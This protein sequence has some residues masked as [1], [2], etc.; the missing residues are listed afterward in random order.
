MMARRITA[1]ALACAALAGCS[2]FSRPKN[3]FYTLETL[4]PATAPA[5]DLVR[6]LPIGIDALE[7]PPG[8]D[9]RGIV[10]LGPDHKVEVRGTNQWTSDLQ[11]MVL[12]TLAFDLADRLPEGMVVLP[13]Q[14]KPDAMRSISI[15]FD[16]LAAGPA[17]AFVLDARWTL[18]T[19]THREQISLPLA[20]MESP[21]IVTEMNQALAMLADR[22]AAGAR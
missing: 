21:A 17:N 13:G 3:T 18:G 6:G 8:L 12:H 19:T 7:L 15:A 11:E 22:I 16:D 1:A 5:A 20:S 14:P 9:R 10:I 2:F 4:P